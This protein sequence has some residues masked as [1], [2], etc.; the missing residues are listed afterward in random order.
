MKNL[1][2]VC[3]IVSKDKKI[4]EKLVKK[5]NNFFWKEVSR[6]VYAHDEMSL[7]I[8][9]IG[10][11]I[12]SMKKVRH[13]ILEVIRNIRITRRTRKFSDNKRAL[14]ELHYVTYLR[15]LLKQHN[16]LAILFNNIE[17]TQKA[18]KKLKYEQMVRDSETTTES[19]TE[20]G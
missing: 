4:P 20:L 19:N 6:Q 3:K 12:H 15:K 8:R 13:E 5:I 7:F 18:N 17:T 14:I 11:F 9:E 1:D 10:T 16:N 2:Y